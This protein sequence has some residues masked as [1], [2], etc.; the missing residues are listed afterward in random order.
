[1]AEKNLE[2]VLAERVKEL[3]CLY[4]IARLAV[5]TEL[6]L[7]ETMQR[8]A[9]LLPAGWQYPEIASARITV[10][11]R[12]FA[13]PG[14]RT[15]PFFQRAEVFAGG[16]TCGDVLIVYLE[17]RSEADEGPFLR[18]ERNLLHTVA[19]ELGLIVERRRAGRERAR[20]TEQLHH[21]DRLAT[22]GQLA[23]GVAHELNEPLVGILGLAQLSSKSAGLPEEVARDL[24]RIVK[25]A[26]HAREVIRKLLLFARRMEPS[27]TRIQLNALVE[28]AL[29]L[30]EF[31]SAHSG[32][33]LVRAFDE[34][35]PELTADPSQ[36]R[37][38]LVNLLVNA[39]QAMPRGGRLEVRTG[40]RADHVFVV[41]AD[42]GVG[43]SEDVQKQLYTPFFTTKDV[44]EGTGL[45]LAVVF[46]I[47]SSHGGTIHVDSD[48]GRGSRFEVRLPLSP[49]FAA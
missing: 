15:S 12:S 3:T 36:I 18:E 25:A 42:T 4:S 19:S 40:S 24:D 31:G 44:G 29:A 49:H 17:P 47:V 9:E 33:D 16:A 38:V 13:S 21:A 6:S 48:V 20:L 37:Q 2:L 45:G 34:N 14:F 41:I 43:M 7:D 8:I 46:G 30:L 35:L 5:D 22:I 11:G 10:E 23:A 27:K 1:M 32:I 26:L 28:E 39:A